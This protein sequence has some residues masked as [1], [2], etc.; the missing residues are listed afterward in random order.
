VSLAA[1]F[2][3]KAKIK[4]VSTFL[5]GDSTHTPGAPGPVP[6]VYVYQELI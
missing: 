3:W 2:A 1:F 4:F 5:L 6:R